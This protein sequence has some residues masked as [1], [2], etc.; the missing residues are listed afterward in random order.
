MNRVMIQ[1]TE[2]KVIFR[3]KGLMGEKVDGFT[4]VITGME[5]ERK[6][7][8]LIFLSMEMAVSS[9]DM[10]S[11]GKLNNRFNEG[12]SVPSSSE[13]GKKLIR[14]IDINF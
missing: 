9:I 13:K 12:V 14:A 2:A 4:G 5:I 7:E 3:D 6:S 10:V 8:D 1:N 11:Q